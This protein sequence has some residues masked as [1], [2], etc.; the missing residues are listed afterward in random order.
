MGEVVSVIT[1]LYNGSLTHRGGY[2]TFFVGFNYISNL[3]IFVVIV[4]EEDDDVKNVPSSPSLLL[5]L[6]LQYMIITVKIVIIVLYIYIYIYKTRWRPRWRSSKIFH[7]W[8][9]V[10][11]G[12]IYIYCNFSYSNEW[13]EIQ[14]LIHL[15]KESW[16]AYYVTKI[17]DFLPFI[18]F[19]L[20]NYLRFKI[21]T[22]YFLFFFFSKIVL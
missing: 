10:C 9:L 7:Y 3:I 1:V 4:E 20:F 21:E 11:H 6:R 17:Q 12:Y 5:L 18:L 8:L 19:Y 15:I 16:V 2:C 22:Q 14:T 13:W